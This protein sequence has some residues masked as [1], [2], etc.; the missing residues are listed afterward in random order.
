LLDA[1]A[2]SIERAQS[3]LAALTDQRATTRPGTEASATTSFKPYATA[4]RRSCVAR[5]AMKVDRLCA[6]SRVDVSSNLRH[7]TPAACAALLAVSSL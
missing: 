4:D 7:R 1:F 2:S 5:G 3:F 6:D